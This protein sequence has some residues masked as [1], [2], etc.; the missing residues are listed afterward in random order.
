MQ[1]KAASIRLMIWTSPQKLIADDLSMRLSLWNIP[2]SI[3]NH[4]EYRAWLASRFPHWPYVE[5]FSRLNTAA[6]PESAGVT[7]SKDDMECLYWFSPEGVM[8]TSEGLISAGLLMVGASPCGDMLAINTR[9]NA[10]LEM[11]FVSHE[12]LWEQDGYENDPVISKA[13]YQ[14][15]PENLLTYLDQIYED[16]EHAY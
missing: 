10:D 11:G 3:G 13:A 5:D 12:L 9:A 4:P 7:L 1:G 16:P 14:V 15:R 6:S 8:N 2:H